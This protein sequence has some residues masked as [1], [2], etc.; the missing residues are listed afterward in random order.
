MLEKHRTRNA[1]ET[2]GGS[3]VALRGVPV[4]YGQEET[5][6][7]NWSGSRADSAYL[8]EGGV[9]EVEGGGDRPDD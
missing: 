6:D 5:G 4:N 3:K 8:A 9:E 7:L 1:E 2:V